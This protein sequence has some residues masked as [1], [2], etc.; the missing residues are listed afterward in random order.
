MSSCKHS[1]T[2][3]PQAKNQNRWPGPNFSLAAGVKSDATS[4]DATPLE[5]IPI[6]E[7]AGIIGINKSTLKAPVA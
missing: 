2:G 4:P 3:P 6:S 5:L 7:A 1:Q